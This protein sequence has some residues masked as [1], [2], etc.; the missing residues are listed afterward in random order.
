MM[1]SITDELKSFKQQLSEGQTSHLQAEEKRGV[2]TEKLVT[3]Q[4]EILKLQ[5][6]AQGS[7]PAQA[8]SKDRAATRQGSVQAPPRSSSAAKRNSGTPWSRSGRKQMVEAHKAKREWSRV[9]QEVINFLETCKAAQSA[10]PQPVP[11]LSAMMI[12]SFS[13]M[14]LKYRMA[15][16]DTSPEKGDKGMF[17]VLNMTGAEKLAHVHDEEVEEDGKK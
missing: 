12:L 9:A 1:E 8:S 16:E 17:A 2:A 13:Y 11:I 4:E 10:D 5:R 3:L 6:S 14:E 15:G 7:E